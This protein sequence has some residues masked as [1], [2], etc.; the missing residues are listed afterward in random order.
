MTIYSISSY[1]ASALSVNWIDGD[2]YT[3]RRQRK[4]NDIGG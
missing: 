1:T 4:Y 3:I 2:K